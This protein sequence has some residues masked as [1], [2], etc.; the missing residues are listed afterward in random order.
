MC[1]RDSL[2]SICCLLQLILVTTQYKN[3]NGRIDSGS[4]DSSPEI[5]KNLQQLIKRD[6]T[7]SC[8]IA[9]ERLTTCCCMEKVST[10][11]ELGWVRVYRC[12]GLNRPQLLRDQPRKAVT[13]SLRVPA[14][15]RDLYRKIRGYLSALLVDYSICVFQPWYA[16]HQP[17]CF[18]IQP[19]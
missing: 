8:S 12:E 5:S 4:A 2:I 3:N 13:V 1:I 7:C 6:I 9:K 14:V 10:A 16:Y 17:F 19:Y 11:R 15:P 18:W